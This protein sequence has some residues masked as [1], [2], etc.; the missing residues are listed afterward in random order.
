MPAL[1]YRGRKK[2][3]HCNGGF[4]ACNG[5]CLAA[6]DYA[7]S[8]RQIAHFFAG[9][10]GMF[11]F[12]PDCLIVFD[13]AAVGNFRMTVGVATEFHLWINTVATSME[14]AQHTMHDDIVTPRSRRQ[15]AIRSEAADVFPASRCNVVF[16]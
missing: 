2:S 15:P 8:M 5:R 14:F 3:N 7:Q 16:G 11:D 12:Q 1:I 9:L 10:T 6:G 13:G 4:D